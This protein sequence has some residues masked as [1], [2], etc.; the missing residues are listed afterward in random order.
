MGLAEDKGIDNANSVFMETTKAIR[1]LSKYKEGV[2]VETPI[3]VPSGIG[4]FYKI[5]YVNL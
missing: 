3:F 4:M 1:K 2:S 5:I